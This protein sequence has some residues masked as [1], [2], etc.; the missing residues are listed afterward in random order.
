MRRG[1]WP[2]V[3]FII[4]VAAVV[5]ILVLAAERGGSSPGGVAQGNSPSPR[6]ARCPSARKGFVW[7][8]QQRPVGTGK[9]ERGRGA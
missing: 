6:V 2:A 3:W 4:A 8:G 7:Y 5:F 9:W 1:G